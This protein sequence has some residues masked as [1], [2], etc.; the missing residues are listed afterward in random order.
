MG[1]RR[2]ASP[3]LVCVVA[4]VSIVVGSIGGVIWARWPT[5][6]FENRADW[7]AVL[8]LLGAVVNAVVVL[9]VAIWITQKLADHASGKRFEK[10]LIVTFVKSAFT[11]VE[12]IDEF[13]HSCVTRATFTDSDRQRMVELFAGLAQE[14]HLIEEAAKACS[15]ESSV[16]GAQIARGEYKDVLTDHPAGAAYTQEEIKSG[17]LKY[18]A[19]RSALVK[20]IVEINRS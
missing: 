20:I 12:R 1:Q 7:V 2:W 15:I 18:A 5:M 6:Q 11:A 16:N 4:I 3:A 10:E 19:V 8:G 17:G 14:I 9:I 13:F